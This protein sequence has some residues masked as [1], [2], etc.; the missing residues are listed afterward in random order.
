[1]KYILR[2]GDTLIIKELDR[3]GRNKLEI[4][5]ELEYFKKNNVYVKILNIP[6]TLIDFSKYEEQNWIFDMINNIL[7][8]VL[9]A[10]A[11]E[12]RV[13]IR[14]RQRESIDLAKSKGQH[15]WRPKIENPENYAAVVSDWR[16]GKITAVEAMKTLGLSR[17][18]FYRKVKQ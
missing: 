12:E 11:E 7:I 17:S 14:L 2:T 16:N 15:L 9:G 1:M 5:N 8:E 6:T 3:L 13:K 4:K 18:T 10:I